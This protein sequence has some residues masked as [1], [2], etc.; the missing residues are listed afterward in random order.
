MK[1]LITAKG[2]TMLRTE[3][4]KRMVRIALL[5]LFTIVFLV[6][7]YS[8]T[9]PVRDMPQAKHG[10]LDLSGW[11]LERQGTV[12]LDGE[13]EFYEGQLLEPDD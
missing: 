5:F 4:V 8:L 13:W 9:K 6:S 1:Q 11:D 10:V 12:M 2:A 7:I 3:S